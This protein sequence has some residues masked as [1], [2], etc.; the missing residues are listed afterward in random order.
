MPATLSTTARSAKD[1]QV[2]L[3]CPVGK[4]EQ[5][6]NRTEKRGAESQGTPGMAVSA[7][8][9]AQGEGQAGP[10][11]KEVVRTCGFCHGPFTA[12][13]P[14]QKFCQDKCKHAAWY[15]RDVLKKAVEL[16]LQAQVLA[17]VKQ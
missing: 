4:P 10:V 15:E 11:N 2:R 14:N 8:T 3:S 9:T 13:K 1:P 12:I 16:L 6:G 17:R 5:E 7:V